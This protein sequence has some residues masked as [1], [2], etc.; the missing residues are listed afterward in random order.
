MVFGTFDGIHP[1]HIN[2]LEQAGKRGD[3]LAV[4]VARDST[5]KKVKGRLPIKNENE[6]LADILKTGLVNKAF[7]GSDGGDPYFII[8]NI[9]PDII[10]LGYDQRTYTE[11]LEDEVDKL[12][13][14]IEIFRMDPFCPEKYHSGII[15]KANRGV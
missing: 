12:G 8:N 2:F 6:R 14:K 4:V 15:N 9:K 11:G 5:V 1:G 3:C 13:L 7:L 10:C